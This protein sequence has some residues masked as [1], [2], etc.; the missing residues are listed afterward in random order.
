MISVTSSLIS[1]VK[2][3][4]ATRELVV[5]FKSGGR[6]VYSEVPH[7][8]Y[9]ALMSAESIGKYFIKHIK[10]VFKFRQE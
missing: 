7:A 5:L 4:E 8:A 1:Q 9:E 2:Y 6:Y 3:D 10:T